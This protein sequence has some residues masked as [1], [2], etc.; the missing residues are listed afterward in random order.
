[1]NVGSSGCGGTIVIN[2]SPI[3]NMGLVR[4]STP[5]KPGSVA[6][7]PLFTHRRANYSGSSVT[8]ISSAPTSPTKVI[9]S[10]GSLSAAL[11]TAAGGGDS[12]LKPIAKPSIFTIARK[13]DVK[14]SSG[15]S[16]PADP[17]SPTKLRELL[18]AQLDLIQRQS[19]AI[20]S[21][22]R[23]LQQLRTENKNLIQKLANFNENVA[24]PPKKKAKLDKAIETTDDLLAGYTDA[25]QNTLKRKQRDSCRI[26]KEE[27]EKEEEKEAEEEEEEEVFVGVE[28]SEPYFT[29]QGEEFCSN[30]EQ[31]IKEILSQ[32][33]CPKW[34]ILNVHATHNDAGTEKLDDDFLLKRHDKPEMQEKRRKRW[35]MQRLR[36]QRQVERLRARSSDGPVAENAKTPSKAEQATVDEGGQGWTRTFYPDPDRATHIVVEDSLP[37]AAFGFPLPDL[38]EKPF[39]PPWLQKEKD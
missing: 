27:L 6:T 1:M 38:T 15:K 31:H 9:R 7:S 34:R 12:V 30:E 4:V 8:V 13:T 35:D 19:E 14:I 10:S 21:K 11:R 5:A 39:C 24:P 37:V 29:W 36:Q 2:S 25:K 32:S 20:V 3:L 17:G 33:E 22:D 26:K 18:M 23:Q 28:C 16:P